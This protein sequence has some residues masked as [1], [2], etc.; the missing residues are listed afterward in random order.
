MGNRLGTRRDECEVIELK[1]LVRMGVKVLGL[2]NLVEV[3]VKSLKV[4][5]G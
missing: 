5:W 3:G 4:S 2:R 1:I